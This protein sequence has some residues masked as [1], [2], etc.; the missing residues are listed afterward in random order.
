MTPKNILIVGDSLGLPRENMP[1]TNTWPFLLSSKLT[2]YHFIFKLQRALTTKTINSGLSEDWLEFY[3]P[4]N[5]I[6]QVGI[7]DCSPRYIK[8]GGLTMKI[9]AVLPPFLKAFFWKITKQFSN[10][11]S[12]YADVSLQAFQA[13]I[14]KYIQRCEKIGVERIFIIKIARSGSNMIKQN[15]KILKQIDLYNAV[16][17]RVA[18]NK[19]NCIL[20]STLEKANDDYFLEDGYHLNEYGNEQVFEELLKYYE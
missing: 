7:V 4:K 1:Y 20:I 9:L 15:P 2:N 14:K 10:R 5:I 19:N 6:L 17:E 3:N 11:K 13:N 16:F 8:N 12:K 18:D